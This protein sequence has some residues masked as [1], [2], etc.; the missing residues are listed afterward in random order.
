MRLET[1]LD[2]IAQIAKL[3]EKENISFQ[4]YLKTQNAEKID[5]IVHRL[6]EDILSQINCVDC[7]NCCM[8]LRPIATEKEL[9]PFV[10]PENMQA[11]MYLKAFSCKHIK[12]KK[13]IIYADR[14]EECRSYPY[15]HKD[16]FIDRIHGVLQNYEI[17]PIV[18]NVFEL[19][20]IELKWSNKKSNVFFDRKSAIG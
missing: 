5:E 10:A 17:C 8:N 4:T 15:L 14:P 12:D 7:G 11:F 18:F 19:L 16:N 2:N 13:C 1:E 9:R 6:Y 3:K 20:K